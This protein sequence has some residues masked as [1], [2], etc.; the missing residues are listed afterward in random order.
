MKKYLL[1]LIVITLPISTIYAA[2]WRCIDETTIC[3]HKVDGVCVA[4]EIICLEAVSTD[5]QY[6]PG[7]DLSEIME[8]VNQD[9]CD[10]QV[11]CNDPII[12]DGI[13]QRGAGCYPG[14]YIDTCPEGYDV[15]F[16]GDIEAGNCATY[17]QTGDISLS[18]YEY[19]H[20]TGGAAMTLQGGEVTC[21]RF[22]SP[23]EN[24]DCSARLLAGERPSY[25]YVDE[26]ADLSANPRC[27]RIDA[28]GTTDI[29]DE[30]TILN[31]DCVWIMDPVNGSVCST[32]PNAIAEN[33]DD[34]R[35]YDVQT[36]AYS[37][38]AVDVRNCIDKEYTMVCP[39]GSQTLCQMQRTC[40]SEATNTYNVNYQQN[41]QANRNYELI[42]C[43]NTNGSCATYDNNPNCVYI[44]VTNLEIDGTYRVINGWDSD[45]GSQNCFIE[46]NGGCREVSPDLSSWAA[47]TSYFDA[48]ALA[49][50][51][52]VFQYT[53][54]RVNSITRVGERANLSS[55]Y[56]ADNNDYD[57]YVDLDITYFVPHN[58]YYC[59]GDYEINL[60]SNCTIN[61]DMSPLCLS[62][63]TDALDATKAT[64][65]KQEY[66]LNCTDIRSETVCTDYTEE[67][68]CQDQDITLPRVDLENDTMDEFGPAL[69]IL[70][71]LDDINSIWSGDNME[72]SYGF[73]NNSMSLYCNNCEGSGTL[74]F[75]QKP[76]QQKAYEMNKKGLCHY[77]GSECSNEIDLGFGSVCIERTK[78]FCCYDS[79]L[80]RVIVEQAYTQLN[81][82]WN[83]GCNGLTIDDLNNLD[84]STMDFS[85]IAEELENKLNL[86]GGNY[87]EGLKGQIQGYYTDFSD[88]MDQTGT[89]P[90][91]D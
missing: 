32:D 28:L 3:S 29:G 11:V 26:C 45:G 31:T 33:T 62:Y 64:C 65:N 49:S 12:V 81:K 25:C 27:E 42:Q 63:S 8:M 24:Y 58:Q 86:E 89:H 74:C 61:S 90:D 91:A 57:Q 34:I 70:G 82:N 71:M 84:W 10:V 41:I 47:C 14:I 83:N 30:T 44:G 50:F 2:T 16:T 53:V 46:Y 55:C 35:L 56:G 22:Y 68:I 5:T 54:S 85:E 59:Y 88:Q 69:G 52:S 60:P 67:V 20:F 36:E 40:I 75:N 17:S 80:A 51:N 37:C 77:L 39:D 9:H 21:Q 1:F 13:C 66:E 87:T 23:R 7:C 76:N 72:C 19:G 48:N 18:E 15:R 78:S 43:N 38:E 79:K 73:F 6:S 4:S